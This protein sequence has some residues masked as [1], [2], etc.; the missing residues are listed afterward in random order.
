M[1][2]FILTA[3]LAVASFFSVFASDLQ[4]IDNAGL[5]QLIKAHKGKTLVVFWAPWCPHCMRE[6][7]MLRENPDFIKKN[8]LQIIAVT[9]ENDAPFASSTIKA[10]KLPFTFRIGTRELYSALLKI[11]A[12]PFTQAYRNNG[13]LIDEEYGAQR[14]ED[15]QLML[16]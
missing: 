16:D 2:L 14:I 10:E 13:S 3:V 1:R 5:Q 4:K 11:D 7:R 6:L 15:I 8:N 9:K 12:V